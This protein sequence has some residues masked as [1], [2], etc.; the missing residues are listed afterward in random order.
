M[1]CTASTLPSSRRI[2]LNRNRRCSCCQSLS[3]PLLRGYTAPRWLRCRSRLYLQRRALHRSAT[4]PPDD[5]RAVVILP[6]RVHF[7]VAGL[8]SSA[9]ASRLLLTS[10]PPVTSDFSVLQ[11]RG[12][13]GPSRNIHTSRF[14]ERTGSEGWGRCSCRQPD[15]KQ[16]CECKRRRGSKSRVVSAGLQNSDGSARS[17]K[18]G[19]F[20]IVGR[21]I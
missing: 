12:G 19:V 16:S 7:P 21:P 3:R 10:S 13:K 20:G 6:V 14:G 18:G 11:Q 9:L 17:H 5:P 1:P 2:R 15:G 4:A 8:Y